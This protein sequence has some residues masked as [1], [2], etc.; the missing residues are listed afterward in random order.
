MTLATGTRLG[1]YEIQSAIG[2]GGMGE[3]YRARDTR[4]DRNV[5]IKVVSERLTGDPTALARLEREAR[6][7]AA[8][9]HP[10][11][12]ALHDFGRAGG[13]TYVV[14]ELLEGEPLDRRFAS[15]QLS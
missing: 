6:A 3:V 8:L 12:L 5:A 10:H 1:P 14:M 4:L 7:V 9:S 13:V 2:A 11:I 15:E